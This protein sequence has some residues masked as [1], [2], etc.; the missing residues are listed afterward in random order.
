MRV[1]PRLIA[2]VLMNVRRSITESPEPIADPEYWP[3]TL[4]LANITLSNDRFRAIWAARLIVSNWPFNDPQLW[5]DAASSS[6]VW[7]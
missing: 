7:V 6:T 1:S 4:R 2:S 5:T 3:R